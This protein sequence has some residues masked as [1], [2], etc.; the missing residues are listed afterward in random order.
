MGRKYLQNIFFPPQILQRKQTSASRGF[1]QHV[2]EFGGMK[3]MAKGHDHNGENPH[4]H[5]HYTVKAVEGESISLTETLPSG[6]AR[7]LECH[8]VDGSKPTRGSFRLVQCEG[9]P[10]GVLR[11]LDDEEDQSRA[12][13][14]NRETYGSVSQ[15]N[16]DRTFGKK[17]KS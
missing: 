17:A 3:A 16:W 13:R 5:K 10:E 12:I 2:F 7:T 4:S 14:P 6:E 8:P 15:A 1:R 9:M 11:K